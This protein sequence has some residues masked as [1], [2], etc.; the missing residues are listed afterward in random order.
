M[1]T[2]SNIRWERSDITSNLHGTYN[3]KY[4][5]S[6]FIAH[7]GLQTVSSSTGLVDYRCMLM[8]SQTH[9]HTN[10]LKN[11]IAILVPAGHTLCVHRPGRN[12]PF[13]YLD[14]YVILCSFSYVEVYNLWTQSSWHLLVHL[15]AS[16]QE[17]LGNGHVLLREAIVHTQG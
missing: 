6:N 9:I 13:P 12:G 2:A 11:R 15:V 1:C 17:T 5:H 8:D 14:I 7:L 4:W 10:K 16:V 3:D